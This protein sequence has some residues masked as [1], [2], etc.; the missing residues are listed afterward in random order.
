[1]LLKS[2]QSGT[3]RGYGNQF[4]LKEVKCNV[5]C[6]PLVE[7]LAIIM[8]VRDNDAIIELLRSQILVHVWYCRQG[9]DHVSVR[10]QRERDRE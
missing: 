4:T 1:M 9:R 10:W 8:V 5:D 3:K 7:E 6:H 2:V